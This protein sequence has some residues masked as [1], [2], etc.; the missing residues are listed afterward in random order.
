MRRR[1]GERAGVLELHLFHVFLAHHVVTLPVVSVAGFISLGALYFH[2]APYPRPG[3]SGGTRGQGA[4][5]S[6]GRHRRQF[7][8]LK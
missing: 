8:P 7:G 1:F 4:N 3:R 2:G 6:M 5:L